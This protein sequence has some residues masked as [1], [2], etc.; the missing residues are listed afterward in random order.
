MLNTF[1]RLLLTLPAKILLG[2]VLFYLL[3]SYVAV[4]PLAKKLVPWIADKQ[5]GSQASVGQ[6]TFDPLR[7]KLTVDQFQLNEKSHAPLASVEQL[8]VDLEASGVFDWAWKFKEIR[9]TG[10]K[11]LVAISPNGALNWSTLLAKLNED[12]SPPSDTIPRV[13]IEHIFIKQGQLRYA[14]HQRTTPFKADISP[15]NLELEGFSTLPKDRGDYLIAAIFPDHGG[16]LKWKGDMGVNPVASRGS[17]R[18]EGVKLS[19]LMQ[20]AQEMQLPFN[21]HGGDLFSSFDYDFSLP[22]DQPKLVLTGIKM[23]LNQLKARVDG[24]GEVHAESLV[25][26]APRLDLTRQTQLTIGLQGLDVA[27]NRLTLQ[28][29]PESKVRFD[30]LHATLPTLHLS[31]QAQTQ[32]MFEQL[33]LRLSGLAIEHQQ[34]AL[35][36]LPTLAV[37][38]VA[39]DLAQSKASIAQIALSDGVVT[40]HRNKAGQ[41]DWQQVFATP[42][43]ASSPTASE[44]QTQET[45]TATSA[46]AATTS[47]ASADSAMFNV[48]IE[49]VA[50]NRWKLKL[51]DD[52]FVNPLHL[53]V[54][55]VQ[56]GFAV[57]N[58]QGQWALQHLNTALKHITLSS[59]L[60][61]KPAATLQ[62][63]QLQEGDIA[64]G[65]QQVNIS[66]I[67]L[68]GLNTELIH[69]PNAPLNW[70]RMLAMHASAPVASKAT[71]KPSQN[72]WKLALKKVALTNGQLHI[73]DQTPS[74]AVT[75]DVEKIALEVRHASLDLTRPVPLKTSFSLKQGG[76]FEAQGKLK[77]QPLDADVQLKLA[78]LSFKPFAPYL[79]QVALLTLNDGNARLQG[80]LQVKQQQALALKF[81]GGFGVE[82]LAIV[83]EASN[84][85]FLAWEQVSSDSLAFSLAPNR[86]HMASLNIRQ[87][88]AKFIINADKT[89]NIARM[90][91]STSN[92]ASITTP[93]APVA[94]PAPKVVNAP[95]TSNDLAKPVL[96][97]P[98]KV[99]IP[100]P[101]S[102]ATEEQTTAEAF[103]VRIETVRIDNAGLEFADLSLTPQFGTQI[104]HLSGVINGVGTDANSTAQ[105]ELD[106]KVDDYG[107]ARIRGSLQPF[108]ATQFTDLKLSFTNLDMSR[109]TPYSGKFAGRRIDAGKLS[110]DLEYKIKQRQ[111]AGENKFV[112]NKLKLGEKVDSAEAA[113]LPL[114]LAIAILE[115]SDGVID[116]DLPITGSLDDPKFSYG[117]IVWKAIRNVLSKIVTAPFRALGKLFGSDGDKLEA[118]LFE[119]GRATLAPP[120]LEKVKAI[121]QALSKRQ[122]L[123]LGIVPSY[124]V[125]LDR[126]A[127]QETA[128]RRQVLTEMGVETPPHLAP[129]PIDL[130]NPKAQKAI[131]TLHDTLTK[132]SLVKRLA[133]KFEK[134][135]AGY[136]ETALETLITNHEVK[137]AELQALAS[138]RG[139]AIQRALAEAGIA[140]ERAR[141]DTPVTVK[142]DAKTLAIATKLTIE[143]KSAS[144]AVETK[145]TAPDAVPASPASE[146]VQ[147]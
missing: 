61:Q 122:G 127:L 132:K 35:L 94:A 130:T 12:P 8:V 85:P 55:D 78:G 98:S 77:P 109:L 126:R 142:G 120:E 56:A 28:P 111:L 58:P 39:L 25:M 108:K 112:I 27:L 129:G 91:R 7:L 125:A 86:L 62:S 11:G 105:V 66:A 44:V 10:P 57:H 67:V 24:M 23:G 9:L 147:P 26:A 46:N 30:Q 144:K 36:A 99:A 32:V 29:N 65:T 107:A 141:V 133:D 121:S 34:Q 81:N 114:D 92:E 6:V 101:A 19:K 80:N 60:F 5:L 41:L 4:N 93:A 51:K 128:L 71:S 16:K 59:S 89:T 84:A 115:D 143:A 50:L 45:P 17:V 33:N 22:N 68:N 37:D 43:K 119:A 83:E 102:P 53:S 116:L 118:M 75:L 31:Q 21:V 106:G 145:A 134:K 104:H 2:L 70:Q 40:A 74:S 113:N 14:D 97:Q 13:M 72:D 96:A 47:V 87:P 103:P 136:Y 1:K 3:F 49:S 138:A 79:N 110:V 18:I 135:P 88:T 15:I 139:K 100:E 117:S 146:P 73:E 48:D 95:I 124:D 52:S 90:L 140:L 76:H 82:Q 131:D 64:L 137:E 69:A 20:V 54:G 63:L 42:A 38:N 123:S